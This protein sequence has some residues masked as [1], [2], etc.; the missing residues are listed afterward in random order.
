[1]RGQLVEVQARLGAIYIHHLTFFYNVR[2]AFLLHV[3]FVGEPL[4]AFAKGVHVRILE[5]IYD[6]DNLVISRH[7]GNAYS[8]VKKDTLLTIDVR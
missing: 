6:H 2:T 8:A 7:S 3:C 4:D 5:Y 1:M